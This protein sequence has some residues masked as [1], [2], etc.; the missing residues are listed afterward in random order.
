MGSHVFRVY[1]TLL[2]EYKTRTL[3]EWDSCQ[4]I[5]KSE[6]VQGKEEDVILNCCFYSSFYI[7][8][9]IT[10]IIPKNLKIG[11]DAYLIFFF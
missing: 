9:K 10:K 2:K 4:K 5:N 1:G 8:E 3:L 6:K 11:R 7:G